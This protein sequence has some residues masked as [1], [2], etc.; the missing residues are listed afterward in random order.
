M[1]TGFETKKTC[2]GS[3]S[4]Y[5]FTG[6]WSYH[7]FINETGNPQLALPTLTGLKQECGISKSIISFK[8]VRRYK[9][10][11]HSR[12]IPFPFLISSKKRNTKKMCTQKA[13]KIRNER[14]KIIVIRFRLCKG[15]EL[16]N[17][18]K[19][20]YKSLSEGRNKNRR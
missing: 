4:L 17:R 8:A 6:G 15:K 9:I 2:R 1:E 11:H 3:K 13:W 20:Y 16:R 10:F 5:C 12:S 18:L 19:K 14:V 7:V